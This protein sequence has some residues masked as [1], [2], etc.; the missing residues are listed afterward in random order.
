MPVPEVTGVEAALEFQGH[1]LCCFVL[2]P[3][4]GVES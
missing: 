3:S 4:L 2:E 1:M